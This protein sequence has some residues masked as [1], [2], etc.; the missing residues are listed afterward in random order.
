MSADFDNDHA[1][2]EIEDR[3]KNTPRSRLG[4]P[5][6]TRP[7]G[8]WWLVRKIARLKRKSLK[9]KEELDDKCVI[10]FEQPMEMS[11]GAASFNFEISDKTKQQIQ[12]VL[13]KRFSKKH[14]NVQDLEIRWVG[15]HVGTDGAWVTLD[16][17]F[18]VV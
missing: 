1:L 16:A 11:G 18:M 7:F 2:S 12:N 5:V 13:K 14:L 15:V 3:F 10:E 4:Y 8:A 9:K 17:E 6:I